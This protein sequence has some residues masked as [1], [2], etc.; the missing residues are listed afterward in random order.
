M[1]R[2]D[3]RP[4]LDLWLWAARFFRSR[5]LATEAIE[6]GKVHVN[7]GRARPSRAVH[8]GDVLDITRAGERLTV[9]VRG[10]ARERGSAEVAR[11]LYEETAESLARRAVQAEQRRLARYAAPVFEDGRPD[12]R[13]RAALRKLKGR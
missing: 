6:G 5:T 3:E 1:S 11:T 7:G 8:I 2:N 10:L 9:V 12:R 13:G 4:R